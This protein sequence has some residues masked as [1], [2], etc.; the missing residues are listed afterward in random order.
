M[1]SWSDARQITK[2]R[3]RTYYA[4][5]LFAAFSIVVLVASFYAPDMSWFLALFAC[6]SS[7]VAIA[8]YVSLTSAISK[9][10]S[11][12]DVGSPCGTSTAH[13]VR[14]CPDSHLVDGGR[15]VLRDDPLF[16]GDRVY[17][18][19]ESVD[20]PFHGADGKRFRTIADIEGLDSESLRDLCDRFRRQPYTALLRMDQT[21]VRAAGS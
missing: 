21:C 10:A 1:S 19:D 17:R 6:G 15:C 2:V 7:V 5:T 14:A 4:S 3:A 20:S 18:L 13:G 12:E 16:A 11:R 8:C 9:R